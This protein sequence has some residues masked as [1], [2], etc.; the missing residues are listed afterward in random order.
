MRVKG[1]LGSLSVS[2]RAAKH[3]LALIGEAFVVVTWYLVG[4]RNSYEVRA[5]G[6]KARTHRSRRKGKRARLNSTPGAIMCWVP[7]EPSYPRRC[8][9]PD[10]KPFALLLSNG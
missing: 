2:N 6:A 4:I 3:P 5:G 7:R 1:P 10:H 9:G 8:S